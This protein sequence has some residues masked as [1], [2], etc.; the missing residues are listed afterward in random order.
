MFA[1]IVYGETHPVG[2]ERPTRRKQMG[3]PINK[4]YFGYDNNNNIRVQFHNGT[5]SVNGAIV[6]QRA[7]KKFKCVDDTGTTAICTLTNKAD[8][9]LV[10]GDMTIKVKADDGTLGFVSKI[11]LHKL[12]AVNTAGTV[13]Y[14]GPW[15][16]DTST[17]DG[18]I[19]VEE[20]GNTS[21]FSG[22]VDITGNVA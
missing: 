14:V 15:N 19:Q 10:A 16:F 1:M 3:R 17:S 7:S 8:A 2:L 13:L 11:S 22:N 4:K 9:N 20:S 6:N 18:F 21:V 12:T 5:S